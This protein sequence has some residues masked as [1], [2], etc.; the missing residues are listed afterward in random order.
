MKEKTTLPPINCFL[1][2][3]VSGCNLNCDYCYMYNHADQSWK[4]LPGAISRANVEHLTNRLRE[5]VEAT[6][7]KEILV[8]F[9]GGEPLLTGYKRIID[10]VLNIK[11]AFKEIDCIVDFS[12]Q[13]NGT[14]LNEE[15]VKAFYENN[16]GVSI[17]LD[18]DRYSND[19]HRLDKKNK[20]TFEKV[21]NGLNYLKKYP[22]IFTGVISVIDPRNDPRKLF[23]F[24]NNL[25]VPKLDFLLP[26]ANYI[27]P[28]P[29][30]VE[31]PSLY[32]DW[33]TKAF[34]IWFESYSHIPVRTFDSLIR[35]I[36]GLPSDTDMFGLGDVSLLNIET[37]GTYH[38]LD[39]LRITSEGQ[40]SLGY[41]LKE[42]SILEA[43][44]SDKI[45][46]HRKI[47]SLEGL[48]ETCKNCR[49]VNICGGGSVPHRYSKEGFDNP[50]IYC[51]EMISLTDLVFT[52]LK[53]Q[54][55]KLEKKDKKI[56]NSHLSFY[57]YFTENTQLLQEV[58]ENWKNQK[59]NE[60]ID[61]I[62]QFKVKFKDYKNKADIL[63]SL[64]IDHIKFIAT[65]PNVSLWQY[66]IKQNKKIVNTCGEVI[67]PQPEYIEQILSGEVI[68]K[69]FQVHRSDYW[70]QALFGPDA[71]IAF[72]PF[73]LRE[74]GAELVELSLKIIKDWNKAL[75][76]E[77]IMICSEIH[78]VY[79][80]IKPE[81]II[82][83]SDNLLPSVLYVSIRRNGEF[84]DPFDLAD[85][86]IH[87]YRHQKLY[88]LEK[89]FPMVL[90]DRPFVFSPWRED[91]RPPS[92]VFHAIFVF[93][94]LLEYWKYVESKNFSADTSSKAREHVLINTD[95]L[96][97]GCE[98]LSKCSLTQAGREYLKIFK[99][100]TEKQTKNIST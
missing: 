2:K 14:L 80:P 84:I 65:R 69:S 95:R 63:L 18:G 90:L 98:V 45:D 83:F 11:L 77:I 66:V 33:L 48:S 17:S 99:K 20:S 76:Q 87:E 89:N 53:E 42:H 39:V 5:Y 100:H 81:R 70:L 43:I 37:D 51:N 15:N 8:I 35:C 40:S 62:K 29:G 72:E 64:P 75:Y 13:T 79:D 38:D 58:H 71:N 68:F 61:T 54:N 73:D 12:L 55:E 74:K 82:S 47:L 7:Q 1:V 59:A 19:L 97:K 9:H 41:N 52:K 16:I 30:R 86:I 31:N 96:I 93:I 56:T 94:K 85:S 49:I 25:E 23:E 46:F 44:K 6:S 10:I 28:P 60:F 78:F 91:F 3:I 92:G 21:L 34:T 24:F 32:K 36:S 27:T 67:P 50:T 26:D 57:E 88:L 22:K 4:D